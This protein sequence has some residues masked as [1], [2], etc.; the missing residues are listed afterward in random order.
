MTMDETQRR[1]SRGNKNYL[2]TPGPQ[3]AGRPPEKGLRY[4]VETIRRR[5]M[6]NASSLR[7]DP[8]RF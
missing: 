7:P 4:D 5:L 1:L 8:N 2:G 3:G 6:N